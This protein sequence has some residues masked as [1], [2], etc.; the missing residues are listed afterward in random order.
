[1][2][3]PLDPRRK[4]VRQ[5]EVVYEAPVAQPV[6][7]VQPAVQVQPAVPVQ[8]VIAYQQPAAVPVADTRRSYV[9]SSD[10][11]SEKVSQV[12]YDASGNLVQREEQVFE[13]TYAARANSLD[14]IARIIQFVFGLL[15]VLLALRFLFRVINAGTG[16]GLVNFIYN[17]TAP[18][19]APF[20]GIFNDQALNN[21]ASVVEFS[22]LIA[23]GIY[24]LLAWGIVKMLY[25]FFSPDHSTKEVFSSSR[26]RLD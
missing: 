15:L 7:P 22:T 11:R 14:R 2:E 4:V 13:D 18:F 6:V 24:A 5:D 19:V 8:P 26:R 20:N 3:E 17:I 23:I 10:V 9:D 1:M 12:N 16:N 21:N 25:V